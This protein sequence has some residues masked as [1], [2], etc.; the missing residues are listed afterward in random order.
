MAWLAVLL[1]WVAF[2]GTHVVL[3]GALRSRIVGRLGERG[4]QGL[5]SL[6]A[7]ATFVPLVWVYWGHK[8]E[9]ALLWSLAGTPGVRPFGVALSLLG[10]A[11]LGLA[12]AQPSATA[13]LPSAARRAR[14][15]S[16]ITRH[17]MLVGIA[18]FGAAHALLNGFLSDVAFFG[19]FVVYS[20]V[21]ALHQ[22]ARKRALPGGPLADYYAETSLVPFAAIA[23]GRNRLAL[24]E[25][26]W[27]GA[28]I[29]L[30]VG[31]A[32]FWLHP[33]LFV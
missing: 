2:G 32:L 13:Q 23:A 9:G 16:R 3:S 31:V 8:H 19:G 29:G 11:F 21:G 10:F 4:Y 28:A 15:V 27:V 5:F 7:L 33:W 12:F 25:I 30:A 14:G 18:L 24:G 20:V 6:V 26:S 17:P 22:D 1:L